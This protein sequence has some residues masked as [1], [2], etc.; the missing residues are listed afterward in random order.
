MLHTQNFTILLDIWHLTRWF[1][2]SKGKVAFKWYIPKNHE[3]LGIKLYELCDIQWLHI[4]HGSVLSER[5]KTDHNKHD[6]DPC[7]SVIMIRVER[8]GHKL[9]TGNNFSFP[10]DLTKQK[11]KCWGT[12]RPNCKGMLDDFKSKT[13]KMKQGDIRDRTNC[14]MTVV[15]WKDQRDV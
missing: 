2:L 3:R 11:I 13:L 5:Q 4:W 9:Y 8:R 1:V 15:V 6:S 14:D 12:V 10:D 7:Y